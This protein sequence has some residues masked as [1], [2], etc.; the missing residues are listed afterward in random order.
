MVSSAQN[1]AIFEHSNSIDLYNDNYAAH[2][3]SNIKIISGDG[4]FQN[5]KLLK[6]LYKTTKLMENA[7][8]E[9]DIYFDYSFHDDRNDDNEE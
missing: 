2:S 1:A 7:L 9:P 6:F 4:D 3:N 5:D 8:N